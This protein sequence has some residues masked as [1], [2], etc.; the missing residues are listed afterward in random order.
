VVDRLG[1]HAGLE[2]SR[3]QELIELSIL[4]LREDLQLL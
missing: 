1:A 4:L 2:H 3:R